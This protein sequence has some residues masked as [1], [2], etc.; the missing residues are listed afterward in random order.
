MLALYHSP[1]TRSHLIR[2]ALEELGLPYQLRRLDLARAEHKSPAYLDVNPLGQVP[3]LDDG[4]ILREA[5]AIALH[6]GDKAPQAR[7]GLV[8]EPGT[9]ERGPYYQWVVFSIASELAALAK[10]VLHTRVLPEDA[11]D[12]RALATGHAEWKTVAYALSMA[13]AGK[14]FLIGRAFSLADVMVGGTLWLANF[15]GVLAPDSELC[16]YYERVSA[17][18]AFQ[19]AYA[20]AVPA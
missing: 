14:P 9:P 5:A 2:F 6:L 3:T 7:R 16:R 19:R 12:P 18:P 17:R 11:R 1:F 15:V 13:L 8:P 20:D 10:I 4:L